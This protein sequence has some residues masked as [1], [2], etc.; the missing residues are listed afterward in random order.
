MK[1][2]FKALFILSV[3]AFWG[4]SAK[5][6]SALSYAPSSCYFYRDLFVGSRGEDVRCLQQYL[7]GSG[8]GVTF[9]SYGT[10]DGV[11]GPLTQQYLI[12]WQLANGLPATGYFD[13]TSRARLGSAGMVLGASTY[14]P[15]YIPDTYG[16]YDNTRAWNKIQEALEMIEDAEDAIDDSNKSTSKAEKKLDGAKDDIFDSVHSYFVDR[17]FDEAFDRAEDAYDNAEDAYDEADGGNSGSKTDAKNAIED[18]R[19]A[20]EDA[21][22]EI[23]DARRRGESLSAINRAEDLVDDAED[24]LDKADDEYDDKDYDNAEDYANDAEDLANDAIDEIN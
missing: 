13:A 10:P 12:Q 19:D 20:I 1:T 6:S 14:V 23:D 9:S 16:S 18:A 11:F 8:Y 21:R 4:A 17:D 24:K 15:E 5:D 2:L 22:D 7:Q 3:I